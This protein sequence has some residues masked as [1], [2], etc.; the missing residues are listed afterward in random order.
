[1]SVESTLSIVEHIF[2]ITASGIAIWQSVKLRAARKQRTQLKTMLSK[3]L[4]HIPF[5]SGSTSKDIVVE[6]RNM[7]NSDDKIA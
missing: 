3:V 5:P 1:M 4:S 2:V 7:I 6:A